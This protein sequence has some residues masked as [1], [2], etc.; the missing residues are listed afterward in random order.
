MIAAL[1]FVA[2]FMLAWVAVSLVLGFVA[3]PLLKRYLRI[4][5]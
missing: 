2:W 3:G 5:L 4:N 1:T